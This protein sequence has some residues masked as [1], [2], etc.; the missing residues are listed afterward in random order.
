VDRRITT[1]GEKQLDIVPSKKDTFGDTLTSSCKIIF[2][3]VVL[4]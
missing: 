1:G 2:D 3:D 4:V